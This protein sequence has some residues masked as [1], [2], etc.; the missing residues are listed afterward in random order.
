M[1]R[2]VDRSAAALVLLLVGVDVRAGLPRRVRSAPGW[3]LR[4]GVVDHD[5]ESSDQRRRRKGTRGFLG[6]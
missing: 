4:P 6:Q 3:I 5:V 2:C 1:H